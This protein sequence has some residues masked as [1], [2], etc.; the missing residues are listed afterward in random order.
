MTS[1]NYYEKGGDVLISHQEKKSRR[2]WANLLVMAGMVP[3]AWSALPAQPL[4]AADYAM[5][6]ESNTYLRMKTTVD[7]RDIYPL[8]EYLRFSVA[9][10]EQDGNT[11]SLHIGGW[12]RVDLADKSS[13][14]D[15]TEADLQFGYLSFQGAKNNLVV[16]A[17]RQFV[18]EGVAAQRLDGLYARSDFA[19]GFAASAY[20][21]TPVVTEPT[22]RA[23]DFVGGARVTHSDKKY[24][25][26]GLS[27]L[28]SLAGGDR[29]RE[30]EGIDIWLSPVKQVDVTGSSSYNSVT[31]GWMEHA[32]TAS[33]APVENLR[34]F[35]ELSSTNYSDYF[36]RVTTSALVFDPLVNGIDPNE[37]LLALGGG[38]SYTLHKNI[39]VAADYRHY[40]YDVARDGNYYG[41]KVSYWVPESQ[42]AGLSVH[43]MDNGDS[44]LEYMEYRL[45]AMKKLGRTNLTLDFIDL[46]YDDDAR[47][48]G[49]DHAIALVVAGTY[50]INKDLRVGASLDY[51]HNPFF[52]NELKGLAKLTYLF[53]VNRSAEGGTKSEN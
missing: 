52:D 11:T 21:G 33:F 28:T 37:E 12:G 40:D 20:A 32:Y 49:V 51:S 39:T 22:L 31:D 14:D 13:R 44:R 3:A 17:G 35:A 47:M 29:Y 10:T 26:V 53:D 50:E 24:Y 41:G 42:G 4:M 48:N 1:V 16:N 36:Y 34:L 38:G 6:G 30:E 8:Y 19:A 9:S 5:S 46:N 2:I 23:D 45:Y 27:F 15:N 7:K 18:V 43:R 25:T